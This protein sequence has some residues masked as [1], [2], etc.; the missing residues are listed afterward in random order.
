MVL[1]LPRRR[2]VGHF[3]VD[4]SFEGLVGLTGEG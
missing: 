2:F 3:A 4:F 1:N